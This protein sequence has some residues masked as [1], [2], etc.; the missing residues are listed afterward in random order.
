[1]D[2]F[3]LLLYR[4][5]TTLSI[6]LFHCLLLTIYFIYYR[7]TKCNKLLPCCTL[8]NNHSIYLYPL[9]SIRKIINRSYRQLIYSN[10]EVKRSQS[11]L[12]GDR[13]Q[14]TQRH[15][16]PKKE[17]KS[18]RRFNHW[19]LNHCQTTTY[20]YIFSNRYRKIEELDP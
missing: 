16:L 15:S 5:S 8:N 2:R 13:A 1:M 7:N 17:Q 20:R 10:Y 19:N 6:N 18:T 14:P 4:K 9:I 11:R 12:P 3:N